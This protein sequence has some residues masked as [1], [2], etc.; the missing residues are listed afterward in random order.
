MSYKAELSK[1]KDKKAKV[2]RKLK[3]KLQQKQETKAQVK[4]VQNEN[5]KTVKSTKKEEAA[6]EAQNVL[7]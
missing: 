1:K 5:V 2:K 4:A 3:Q 6:R 7:P